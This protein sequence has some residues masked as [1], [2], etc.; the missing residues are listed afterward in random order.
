MID[1][2]DRPKVLIFCSGLACFNGFLVKIGFNRDLF[3]SFL[4]F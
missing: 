4:D 1:G 2:G 3:W